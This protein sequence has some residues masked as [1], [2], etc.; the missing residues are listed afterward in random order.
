MT[1]LA[2]LAFLILL[3]P[4]ALLFGADSRISDERDLRTWWP[5][6]PRLSRDRSD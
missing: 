5:G 2:F 1:G 6:T 3:G 4:L